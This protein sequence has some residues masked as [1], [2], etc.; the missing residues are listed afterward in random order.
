MACSSYKA[1]LLPRSKPILAKSSF[2]LVKMIICDG[3]LTVFWKPH[4]IFIDNG[5]CLYPLAQL[6]IF[7]YKYLLSIHN[8][9]VFCITS[10]AVSHM[11]VHFTANE[12]DETRRRYDHKDSKNLISSWLTNPSRLHHTNIYLFFSIHVP[13]PNILSVQGT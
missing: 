7:K 8:S 12:R 2:L 11:G 1:K 6:C 5:N 10:Y 4:S 3:C 13:L 9:P